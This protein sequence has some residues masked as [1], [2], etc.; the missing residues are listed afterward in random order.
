M[1][2]HL[3]FENFKSWENT[4]PIKMGSITGF[5]GTNSSGKTALLQ[6]LLMLKQTAETTD[7]NVVL[8][9]GD[10]RVPVDLGSPQDLLFQHDTR[11]ILKW[12][13][14]WKLP[15]KLKI[16][17]PEHENDILFSGDEMGFSAEVTFRQEALKVKSFFYDFAGAQFGM[18]KKNGHAEYTLEARHTDFRFK[19]F[20]G[21]KWPI[22]S[23]V[24]HYGFSD[25]VRGY[26]QN[27]GFLS[28]FELALEQL[29]ANIYY[30]GP[31]RDY[32]KREYM[33]GGNRPTDMGYRGEKVVE[34]IL[35]S[36]RAKEKISRG[37][38]RARQTLEEIVAFWLKK[39]QLIE[40]FSVRPLKRGSKLFSV[41]VKRKKD[42]PEVLITDVGFGVS[43]ILPVLTLC[44]Y[45]PEGATVILEQPEIHL[46][47]SVQ[48][49][50]ADVL[51]D[52]VQTRKI[53]IILESHSEHLLQRLQRR[54]AEE[55][56]AASDIK[57]YFCQTKNKGTSKLIPLQLD[58]LGNITNWP[59]LTMVH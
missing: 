13:L 45:V 26:Y 59:E 5:F 22:T 21:R 43:Q 35:A 19:R 52:A 42:A 49:G 48:A 4:G 17:K 34:A 47:P 20:P 2:T 40:S 24:K 31:L 14:H 12:N 57:L 30:L 29:M 1:I 9:L 10:G 36:R 53:Q 38:G 33:W 7:R 37:R 46:H 41:F 3:T 55:E 44:Y 32:P 39:L 6:F 56:I 58:L 25:K 16:Y 15:Q 51:L 8:N 11:R 54:I 18:Q 28:D 50:L 23:V 27:A